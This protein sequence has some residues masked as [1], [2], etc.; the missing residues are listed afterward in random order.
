MQGFMKK[1]IN[2]S[3]F[4]PSLNFFNSPCFSPNKSLMKS[5]AGLFSSAQHIYNSQRKTELNS[6]KENTGCPDNYRFCSGASLGIE[7]FEKK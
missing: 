1:H 6:I 5:R 2:S 4:P 3:F 7:L